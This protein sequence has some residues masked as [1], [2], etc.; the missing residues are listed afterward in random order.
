MYF[1]FTGICYILSVVAGH[2][3]HRDNVQK[4]E[5]TTERFL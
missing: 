2:I 4:L 1:H 3:L 5:K